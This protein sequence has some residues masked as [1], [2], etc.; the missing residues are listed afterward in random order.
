VVAPPGSNKA[1]DRAAAQATR[2]LLGNGHLRS[3]RRILGLT[4]NGQYGTRPQALVETFLATGGVPP[5]GPGRP[6]F[7][8]SARL[9]ELRETSA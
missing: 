2:A 8:T 5:T 1:V 7:R 9:R 4:I 6:H 3:Q